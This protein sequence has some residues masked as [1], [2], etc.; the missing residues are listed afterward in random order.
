[1]RP[2]RRD[3]IQVFRI[4]RKKRDLL[5][6][7]D[8]RHAN[9]QPSCNCRHCRG[10][11]LGSGVQATCRSRKA[12]DRESGCVSKRP[13]NIHSQG[14]VSRIYRAACRRAAGPVA[15]LAQIQGKSQTPTPVRSVQCKGA[16]QYLDGEGEVFGKHF[17]F[18]IQHCIAI[19][20]CGAA[21]GAVAA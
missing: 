7:R 3:R 10:Y 2:V 16:F 13:D 9:I 17:T 1:M 18:I 4:R 6:K 11:S 21:P 5:W 12:A 8:P 14:Q 19:A 20:A 15:G